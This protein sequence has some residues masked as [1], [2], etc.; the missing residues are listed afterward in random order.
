MGSDFRVNLFRKVAS[1]DMNG[2]VDPKK[3]A[4]NAINM[5]KDATESAT[6]ATKVVKDA[7]NVPFSLGEQQVLDAICNNTSITQKELHE[8]TGIT[9]GTIKRILPRLQEKGILERIG[10]RRTGKWKVKRR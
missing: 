8:L 5:V 7:T 3:F 9:L 10:S 6:N 4:S 1:V 2:V